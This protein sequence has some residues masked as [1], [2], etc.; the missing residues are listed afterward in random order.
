MNRVVGF[1]MLIGLA[2]AC[3]WAVVGWVLG[4]TAYNLLGHSTLV[5]ITAPCITLGA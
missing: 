2:V 3:C 5:A 4:P 1:W